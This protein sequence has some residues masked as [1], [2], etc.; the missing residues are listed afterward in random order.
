MIEKLI[1]EY[2]DNLKQFK[3]IQDEIH[4]G[5]RRNV[6]DYSKYK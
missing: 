2:E 4:S 6:E 5:E 3:K 1:K